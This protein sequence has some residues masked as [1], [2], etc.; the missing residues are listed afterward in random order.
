MLFVNPLSEAEIITLQEMHKNHPLHWTR[1]RAHTIVLSNEKYT[2][3]AIAKIYGVCRQVVALWIKEWEK[4]GLTALIDKKRSGRRRSISE[5]ETKELI[6]LVE[7]EPRSI[8][9]VIAKFN[10]K[11]GKKLGVSTV[12]RICKKAGLKWK[13]I[14][15]SL[16]NKRND[17]EF[18]K[19]VIKIE[20]LIERAD[21]GEI[22]LFYYDESGFNLEPCIPYAWQPIGENIEIPTSHSRRLNVAG[23]IDRN[24]QFES[25]VFEG[26]INTPVVIACFNEFSKIIQKETHVLIDNAPMH[27]SNEFIDNIEKW[28]SEGLIIEF[29]PP[30]CPELN[31][32]EI[33]WRKIKYE[34]MPFSAYESF[35]NLKE[36]LFNILKNIGKDYAIAFT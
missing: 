31:I 27:T 19:A 14:R 4:E 24:C 13:R 18:K 2:V 33:L 5:E 10:D 1:M 16:K 23:F 8:K 17:E 3:Q 6:N 32:I 12:K 11:T 36:E 30:Y 7:E 20:E 29:L 22:D 15:K 21:K 28:Q 26:S 35:N 25:F 9:Q 34:W